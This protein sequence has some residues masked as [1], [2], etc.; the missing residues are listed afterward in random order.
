MR[1]NVCHGPV[2]FERTLFEGT[3]PH[4]VRLC[5][6]CCDDVQVTDH[7]E[8]IKAAADHDAKNVAVHALLAAIEGATPGTG[9]VG[10]PPA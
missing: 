1:C 3:K 8:H 5:R 6:T 7:L 4:T 9:E 10:A 2:I